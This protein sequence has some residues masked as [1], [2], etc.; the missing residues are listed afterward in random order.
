MQPV[1]R[2]GGNVMYKHTQTEV[3][4]LRAISSMPYGGMVT[5]RGETRVGWEVGGNPCEVTLE[6]LATYLESLK[7]VLEGVAEK[8]RREDTEL[9]ELRS[10]RQVL[11]GIMRDAINEAKAG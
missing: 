1:H 4:V 9:R 3:R 2:S 10:H 11:V 7:S 8:S 6:Q 5:T